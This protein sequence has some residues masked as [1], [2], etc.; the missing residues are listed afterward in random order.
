LAVAQAV[1][2][3]VLQAFQEALA[4]VAQETILVARPAQVELEQLDKE[5]LGALV[6]TAVA[7][8]AAAVVQAQLGR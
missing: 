4:A 5:M 8:Q 7:L 1:T 2:L 3:L 6:L